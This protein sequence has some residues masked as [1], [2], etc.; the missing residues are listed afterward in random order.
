MLHGMAT[1]VSNR[2]VSNKFDGG[3]RFN[4]ITTYLA[5]NN[6][7]PQAAAC[8]PNLLQFDALVPLPRRK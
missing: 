3:T 1:I 8:K 7:C 2:T 5:K 4:W 6:G